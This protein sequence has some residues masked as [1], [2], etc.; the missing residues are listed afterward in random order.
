MKEL[1]IFLH[2]G[3]VLLWD[4]IDNYIKRI[5]KTEFDLYIN[6]CKDTMS[7]DDI[8][9]YKNIIKEDYKDVSFYTFE[10]KGSDIGPFFK[11]LDNI[12]TKNKKYDWIIKIHSKSHNEWRRKMLED[13]FPENFDIYYEELKKNNKI[14]AGSY[15]YP[16]DYFNI[17]YDIKNLKMLKIKIITDWKKYEEEYPETKN[18]NVIE[19]NYF[20]KKNKEKNK[21]IPLIDLELYEYLFNDYNNDHNIINGIDKWKIIHEIKS[22]NEFLFYYPGTFLFFKYKI[23]EE[24]FNDISYNDIY[25]SLENDK[26]NDKL[27][28][29][30]THSWER[31]LPII[32]I[33]EKYIE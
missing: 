27:I 23:I 21:Y 16:Y 24:T 29:S 7:I 14:M 19:K 9:L 11:F 31:V 2:L 6:F 8:V 33:M 1:C 15:K 32:F 4:E 3:N 12:R 30:N 5:K 25:N 17:K 20:L 26:P 10:N 28:Q 22:N 13:I 18:M